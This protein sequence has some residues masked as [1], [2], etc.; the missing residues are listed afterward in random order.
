MSEA[1]RDSFVVNLI[2]AVKLGEGGADSFLLSNIVEGNFGDVGGV[3]VGHSQD[4]QVELVSRGSEV[5]IGVT[6]EFSIIGV[7]FS[8]RFGCQL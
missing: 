4:G 6:D 3:N 1:V 2:A 8:G 5:G 7:N